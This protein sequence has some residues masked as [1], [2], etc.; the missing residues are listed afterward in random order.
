MPIFVVDDQNV[1]SLSN[2]D[3]NVE[4]KFMYIFKRVFLARKNNELAGAVPRNPYILNVCGNL[5]CM[6]SFDRFRTTWPT[7]Q[8]HG[9][10]LRPCMTRDT[11][12]ALGAETHL[13]TATHSVLRAADSDLLHSASTVGRMHA[14]QR[15]ADKR[16]AALVPAGQQ[17][18]SGKSEPRSVNPP[19]PARM[20]LTH[21]LTSSQ[22]DAGRLDGQQQMHC[23]RHS[24]H[25]GVP[26]SLLPSLQPHLQSLHPASC[27]SDT[28]PQS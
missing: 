27:S 24:I 13:H 6:A 18:A 25:P 23:A 28:G 11:V 14:S 10:Y 17:S 4:F 19:S 3:D 1:L 20:G 7:R 22:P 16:A 21:P 2:D 5:S 26:V 12:T 15:E 8:L 9:R